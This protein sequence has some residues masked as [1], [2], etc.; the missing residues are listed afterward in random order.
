MKNLLL[1]C[2]P[3]QLEGEQHAID[4]AGTLKEITKDLPIDLVF[5]SSFDKANRTSLNS[6]RGIGIEESLKIFSKIKT[7][8]NLESITDIHEPWQAEVLGKE[9]EYL[10][11]PAFLCRQT[12]LLI[13]AGKTGKKINI[14]KGQFLH[15]SD[16]KFSAEKV[17][18]TGN[19]NIFL[20]E[21]GSCFGY[22]ELVVDFRSLLIM[23]ELGYPV[24]FDATH[25]VQIM[26]GADGKSSGARKY[27]GS[28]AKAATVVG[29]DGL[30]IETHPEP[31]LAPSDG[32][33][34]LPLHEVKPLLETI[35]E[36]RKL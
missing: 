1:F 18:S 8:L 6:Q 29:I 20:C 28:L 10:Q 3:C 32:P 7:E 19:K 23:K 35:C 25:S 11:I 4:I 27:V 31:D 2:G 14:K 21:R 22:R 26:G 16:M 5:K 15:P 30:F 36:I 33:N 13:A 17:A 34:M 24:I 9:L 12:D